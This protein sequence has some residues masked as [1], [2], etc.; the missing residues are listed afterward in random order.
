MRMWVVFTMYEV[1]INGLLIRYLPYSYVL[2]LTN[3]GF[4]M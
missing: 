3:R 2:Y 4:T 1:V